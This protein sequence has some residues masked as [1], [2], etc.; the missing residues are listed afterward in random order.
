MVS[1]LSIDTQSIRINSRTYM[2]KGYVM[3]LKDSIC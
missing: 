1:E 2:D 3:V